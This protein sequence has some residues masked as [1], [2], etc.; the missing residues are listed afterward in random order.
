MVPRKKK[1]CS[2]GIARGEQEQLWLDSLTDEEN[3]DHGGATDLEEPEPPPPGLYRVLKF[4]GSSVGSAP[5][6][7]QVVTI[8]LD[9]LRSAQ[10]ASGGGKR[11][12][13]VVSAPGDT[14]DWLIGAA[15][16]A[17][18]GQLDEANATI[19]RISD[20]A[21]ANSLM[22][23]T[24]CC[25]SARGSTPRCSLQQHMHTP[26]PR[27]PPPPPHVHQPPITPLHT[28]PLAALMIPPPRLPRHQ[29]LDAVL[30]FGER[31]SA[32]LLAALLR[33][34]GAAAVA[35][36]AR[37]W[38][39]TDATFGAARVDGAASRQ[40]L[41]RARALWGDRVAVNTG[42]I[43]S[44]NARIDM[45]MRVDGAA[46]TLWG[47]RIAV[48]TGFIGRTVDGRTTTLGRNGSDYTATL[49]GAGLLAEAVIVNTDVSGV[50]TADPTIV[51]DAQPVVSLSYEEALELATYGSRLFH[52]RTMLPLMETGCRW[53]HKLHRSVCRHC[54]TSSAGVPMLIRNTSDPTG[55]CTTIH[56]AAAS[57]A[58]AALSAA[59][60]A[61]AAR[62]GDVR[63]R[64]PQLL[65]RAPTCVTS[66]ER[67]AL[68]ELGSR[69]LEGAGH[70]PL[71]SRFFKRLALLE[72]SSRRLEGAGHAPLASTFFNVRGVECQVEVDVHIGVE[73]MR[74]EG[75]RH[76]PLASRFFKALEHAG[77]ATFLGAQAAHG[78]AASALVAQGAA[79]EA[80]LRAL[81]AEFRAEAAAGE[82]SAPA[83]LQPVTMLSLVEEGLRECKRCVRAEMVPSGTEACAAR[84]QQTQKTAGLSA[85]FFGALAASNINVLQPCVSFFGASAASNINVLQVGAG[86]RSLSCA[87]RGGDTAAAVRAVHQACNLRRARASLLL[88]AAGSSAWAAR[89]AKNSL[90][91]YGYAYKPIHTCV[92][93]RRSD[94][95]RLYLSNACN[96]RLRSKGDVNRAARLRYGNTCRALS[97]HKHIVEA[98]TP[99]RD[100]VQPEHAQA[101]SHVP[102]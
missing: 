4:G 79:A 97:L 84:N 65:P 101:L 102:T 69:R 71:A 90:G 80:A 3:G 54:Q 21:L 60:A 94:A 82:V 48:N 49:I 62:R 24:R 26:S 37:A 81:A 41:R 18:L 63:R 50:M 98:A 22:P 92:R 96:G 99:Y 8:I 13:V 1:H 44:I 27:L 70:A 91:I 28:P 87:V 52:E 55:P 6:L 93:A 32:A 12:A 15:E 76:A 73:V 85:S 29:A 57:A 68:L 66:L 11:L 39:V 58:A 40:R 64:A 35:V 46:S 95:H 47:D 86:A 30:S 25:P 67:L 72:L 36:D 14:T 77:V 45:Y 51:E 83:L 78:Q 33:R 75:V 20:L 16:Y 19:D 43:G 7:Y 42:F 23:S 34:A 38:L 9:E 2:G 100:V 56:A 61:A 5:K 89:V 17:A 74:L 53:H 59:P 31:L 10:G 88:V